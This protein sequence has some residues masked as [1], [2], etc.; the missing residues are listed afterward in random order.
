MALT[1][2]DGEVIEKSGW[3]LWMEAEHMAR[4]GWEL[5]EGSLA[6]SSFK[7]ALSNMTADGLLKVVALV[8]GHSRNSAAAKVYRLTEAGS[9][10]STSEGVKYIGHPDDRK[11]VK[12]IGVMNEDR[13]MRVL[14]K[15]ATSEKGIAVMPRNL[16]TP[17]GADVQWLREMG[18]VRDLVQITRLGRD[19]VETEDNSEG[20]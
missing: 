4:V 17:M 16:N 12:R 11:P 14:G 3:D 2:G 10:W 1:G 6:Y 9:R 15:L 13:A 7:T 20:S 19:V 18:Y 5:P 8:R